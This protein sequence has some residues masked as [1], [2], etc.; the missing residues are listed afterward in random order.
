MGTKRF[1]E[2]SSGILW[3]LGASCGCLGALDGASGVSWGVLKLA[4]IRFGTFWRPFWRSTG[5]GYGGS[6]AVLGRLGAS[7]ER[8]EHDFR[9]KMKHSILGTILYSIFTRFYVDLQYLQY[10]TKAFRSY[11]NSSFQLSVYSYF[12]FVF[13]LSMYLSLAVW[14][15]LPSYCG[16]VARL[17]RH[18]VLPELPTIHQNRILEPVGTVLETFW[19][20]CERFW[21]AVAGR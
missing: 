1:W 13:A 19:A 14:Y 8:L 6:S 18:S 3:L 10:A 5:R 9:S 11:K 21:G 20:V 2:A 7:L 17:S 16:V 4:Q 12:L 15:S